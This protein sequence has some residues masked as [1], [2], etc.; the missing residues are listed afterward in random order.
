MTAYDEKENVPGDG[1]KDNSSGSL[2]KPKIYPQVLATL[3][4]W[5]S[6]DVIMASH[7]SQ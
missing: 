2:F 5:S 3:A 6:R 7:V 4:G 1:D